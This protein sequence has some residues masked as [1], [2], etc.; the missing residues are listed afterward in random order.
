MAVAKSSRKPNT[1]LAYHGDAKLRA[2]LVREM[3]RHAKLDMLAQGAMGDND[4][5]CTAACAIHSLTGEWA[6]DHSQLA[7][8]LNVPEVLTRLFDRIFEGL[9]ADEAREFSQAWPKAIRAGADLS[10]VWPKL[11]V[12]LLVD[13]TH[14]VIRFAGSEHGVREA[15]ER[16]AALWQRVI[17]GESVESLRAEFEA[18][19]AAAYAACAA[20]RAACA[21]ADAAC[22][23]A[24]AAD[25][26]ADAA[27]CVACAA[28]AA[29][30]AACAAQWL[31]IRDKTLALLE[32]AA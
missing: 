13:P 21:A 26:A 18:A 1:M 29:A 27:A 2:K 9:S 5:G 6:Y 17:E 31:A 32:E 28:C 15:V 14:G 8:L 7:E 24:C 22:A 10:L 25:W 20:A 30:C 4:K 23:A 16:V 3:K 12:W 19:Y 11:A